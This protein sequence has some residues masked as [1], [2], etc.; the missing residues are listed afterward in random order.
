MEEEKKRRD[1]AT[2]KQQ[3]KLKKKQQLLGEIQAQRLQDERLMAER[4]RQ[5]MDYLQQRGS[6]KNQSGVPYDPLTLEYDETV[7]G[8]QLEFEDKKT[9]YRARLR[10]KRLHFE[11]NRNGY[12]PITG[13]K[14]IETPIPKEP[15]PLG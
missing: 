1:E 4:Y 7:A 11:Q 8:K 5:R 3:W 2:K 15:T 6:P 13:E 10:A 12:N 9:I 14:A